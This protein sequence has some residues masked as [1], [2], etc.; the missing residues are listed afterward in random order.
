MIAKSLLDCVSA[1]LTVDVVFS[2]ALFC[3]ALSLSAFEISVPAIISS[4]FV[5]PSPSISVLASVGSEGFKP[6]EFSK[7]SL[8]PSPSESV[9]EL[10]SSLGFD[11]DNSSAA[12]DW[13]SPSVSG[14]ETSVPAFISSELDK[15]SPSMS[16]LA[17]VGSDG[18]KPFEF[19]KSS[20]MPSSS[21]S[22][23]EISNWVS[24]ELDS[25]SLFELRSD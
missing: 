18:S 3:L 9:N 2:K 15:P 13:P 4:R 20:L 7:S 24:G 23:L 25:T 12:S 21:L 14:F 19:S 17:S 11:E 16:A 10:D 6:F 8:M 22:T 1:S 5:I